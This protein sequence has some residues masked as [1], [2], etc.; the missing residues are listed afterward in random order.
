L[1]V[2]NPTLNCL[3]I[4]EVLTIYL[5]ATIA[6]AMPLHVKS[7]KS[8]YYEPYVSLLLTVNVKFGYIFCSLKPQFVTTTLFEKQMPNVYK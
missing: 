5:A 1:D 8:N 4:Y 2:L 3:I 6:I 7:S